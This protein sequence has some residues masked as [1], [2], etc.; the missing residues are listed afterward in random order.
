M[1]ARTARG[2][3]IAVRWA[4]GVFLTLCVVLAVL[5]HH[6]TSATGVS[7]MPSN[8][9]A[10]MSSTA[11]AAHAMPDEAVATLS[12]DSSH[13]ADDNGACAA[14]AMQHCA[15]ASV[16]SV[17]LAVPAQVAFDPLANLSQAVAGRAPGATVGRA[18]P[19][20]SVLSQLRI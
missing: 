17:Q 1:T 18:P 3:G 9:H 15:A 6:E 16:D 7:S 4:Y 12:D 11:H 13:G 5:V 19:D 10:A 14:P 8:A 2:G 20:L